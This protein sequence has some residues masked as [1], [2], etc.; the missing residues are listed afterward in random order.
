MNSLKHPQIDNNFD[1]CPADIVI[2]TYV[3][4]IN[5]DIKLLILTNISLII[6]KPKQS[7]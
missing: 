2:T 5:V 4:T 3:N 1:I 7:P 6:P